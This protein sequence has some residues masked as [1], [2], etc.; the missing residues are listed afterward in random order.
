V[1]A[2]VFIGLPARLLEHMSELFT[3]A[4][5]ADGR[6]TGAPIA[7]YVCGPALHG[8]VD[9]SVI[10]KLTPVNVLLA[11]PKAFALKFVQKKGKQAITHLFGEPLDILAT[12]FGG[13]S[14]LTVSRPRTR[15]NSWR[16]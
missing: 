1:G 13:P 2:R 7:E 15:S 10:G 6:P 9:G 4:A 8:V 16:R 3:E 11:P 12:A 5:A 14:E